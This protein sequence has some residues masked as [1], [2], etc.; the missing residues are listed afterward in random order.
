MSC[1]LKPAIQSCDTG[2]RIRFLKLSIDHNM[3]VH[4]EVHYQAIL[5][6]ESSGFLVSVARLACATDQKAR[7]LWVRD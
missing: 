2:Q 4:N 7:R 6:P 1:T 3:D 5:Y